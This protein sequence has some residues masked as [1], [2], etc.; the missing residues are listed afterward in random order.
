LRFVLFERGFSGF[1]PLTF[2]FHSLL[3][4]DFFS[5]V[6]DIGCKQPVKGT[7]L[8]HLVHDPTTISFSDGMHGDAVAKFTILMIV[9]V[10]L[11]SGHL[12][13]PAWLA[14]ENERF[15]HLNFFPLAC[16]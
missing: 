6:D 8:P 4:F 13:W 9:L 3:D 2:C 7:K 1:V 14:K 16:S 5:D 15:G 10:D 11:P 12:T